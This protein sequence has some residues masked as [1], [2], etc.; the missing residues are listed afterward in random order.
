[1]STID[2]ICGEQAAPCGYCGK[3]DTNISYGL[4]ARVLEPM[5]YETLLDRGWRR[6]GRFLYKPAMQTVSMSW[7]R[8]LPVNRIEPGF[9][10]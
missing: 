8:D 4:I 7:F 1:M 10:S 5:D 3:D 6:S 2:L 9:T